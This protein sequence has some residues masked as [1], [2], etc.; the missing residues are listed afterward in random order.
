M[1][2]RNIL[3]FLIIFFGLSFLTVSYVAIRWKSKAEEL[4][5]ELMI[6]KDQERATVIYLGLPDSFSVDTMARNYIIK[7]KSLNE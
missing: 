4:R 2:L 1:E 5:T 6:C 7:S 3:I